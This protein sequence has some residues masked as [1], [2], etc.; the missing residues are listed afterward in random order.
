MKNPH[1]LRHI[2]IENMFL[3]I[4]G[5]Q[6]TATSRVAMILNCYQNIFIAYEWNLTN[7]LV[8]SH[9]QKFLSNYPEAL[10]LFREYESP[11][12]L[13]SKL[14]KFFQDRGFKFSVIGE[15][16]PGI[17]NK[18]LD[19]ISGFKVIYTVRDIKTWLCKDDIQEY[20]LTHYDT[21]PAAI[22]YSI[23]FLRSFLLKNILHLR[24]EDIIKK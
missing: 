4:T 17:S 5:A 11:L 20:Y 2:R 13:Y 24:M 9:G 21:V 15:K 3:F 6:K 16:L 14:H 19:D 22:D 1:P 8:S 18:L 7:S 12:S 10:F 23:Q